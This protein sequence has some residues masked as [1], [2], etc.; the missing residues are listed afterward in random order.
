MLRTSRYCQRQRELLE[1]ALRIEEREA[2]SASRTVAVILTNLGNAYGDLGQ[3]KQQQALQERALALKESLFGLE[4]REVAVTQTNLGNA[5]GQLGQHKR[6]RAMQERALRIFEREYGHDHLYCA[7][8][9]AYLAEA[10][11]GLGQLPEARRSA[12]AALSLARTAL[13]APNAVVADLA[14]SCALV[15]CAA[16]GADAGDVAWTA[17]VAELEEAVGPAVACAKLQGFH[18]RSTLFWGAAGRE[19]VVAWLA[20]RRE[21]Q[22]CLAEN[23]HGTA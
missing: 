21:S 16:E 18:T 12:H 17:A 8:A 5:Y 19:D 1:R 10:L 20:D 23:V 7:L 13:P 22:L 3:P 9:R 6:Q 11:A 15:A 14:L 4:H 2:P